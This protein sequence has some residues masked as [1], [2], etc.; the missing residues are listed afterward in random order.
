M[1]MNRAVSRGVLASRSVFSASTSRSFSAAPMVVAE[2]VE[3]AIA[4]GTLH[5]L[6]AASQLDSKVRRCHSSLWPPGGAR[7]RGEGRES[8][9]VC[10]P[11]P[12]PARA[13]AAAARAP[14]RA[15]GV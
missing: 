7:A 1:M 6:Q 5:A 3:G 4:P 12:P 14:P 2:H 10:P 9:R 13:R 15:A 11:P 8:A